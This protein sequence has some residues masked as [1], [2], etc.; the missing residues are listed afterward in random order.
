V[1]CP[2]CGL[3]HAFHFTPTRWRKRP[4][5]VEVVVWQPSQLAVVAHFMGLPMARAE[6]RVAPEGG[7]AIETL[8]G[9][10]IASR[11]DFIIKGV[12]GEFYPVK[13]DIF[14]ASYEPAE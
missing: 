12:K 6:D 3:D 11:G 2:T 9:T 10:M 13:P 4:V 7:F 8:E 1:T 14:R 5:V